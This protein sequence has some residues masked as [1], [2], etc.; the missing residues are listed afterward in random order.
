MSVHTFSCTQHSTV[1]LY[2]GELLDGQYSKSDANHAL[3]K[4]VS[5]FHTFLR[6]LGNA[7][8]NETVREVIDQE[9][10]SVREEL[11]FAYGNITVATKIYQLV[12]RIDGV[13]VYMYT[14]FDM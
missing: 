9:E 13:R 11:F 2:V 8:T 3:A 12:S 5:L 4:S 1:R 6:P 10:G 7:L 14:V